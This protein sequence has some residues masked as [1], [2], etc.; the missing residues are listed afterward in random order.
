[1]VARA[2]P[3]GTP[4][5]GA[6]EDRTGRRV[7]RSGFRR[8]L[9]PTCREKR[10]AV[11]GGRQGAAGIRKEEGAGYIPD[12]RLSIWAGV[13]GVPYRICVLSGPCS[14]KN[15]EPAPSFVTKSKV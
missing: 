7:A 15:Q 11:P 3:W 8:H 5:L 6:A 14:R 13:R 4:R 10:P 9:S 2:Y 12:L 1:M